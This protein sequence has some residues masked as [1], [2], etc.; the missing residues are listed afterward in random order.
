MAGDFG[1][2]PA[3]MQVMVT[4]TVVLVASTWG[5]IKFIK[6]FIDNI[7]PKNSNTAHTDAVVISA[8]ISDSRPILLLK[9][10]IEELKDTQERSNEIIEKNNILLSMIYQVLVQVSTKIGH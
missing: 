4:G 9:H 8:D 10:S 3:H 2:L 5:V 1:S 6:P 7:A